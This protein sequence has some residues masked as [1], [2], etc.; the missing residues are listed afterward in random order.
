MQINRLFEIVYLLL[1]KKSVTAKELAERFEVSPRTIYRDID[2]LSEAGIPVYANRGTGGGIRLMEEF[3]L[4]KSYLS[5]AEQNDILS[6]LQGL[7][8]IRVPD[9][10]PVLK[11]LAALFGKE[12]AG[13]IDVD[14][15]SW[16]GGA[17]ERDKF[18]LLKNAILQRKVI[19]FS[20]FSGEGEKT[21]RTVEPLKILF[22]GMGWYLYG[23]CRQKKDFRVF[24]ISRMKNLLG[25]TENFQREIPD[26]IFQNTDHA[27][28]TEMVP[29]VMKIEADQAFRVYDAFQ[30]EEVTKNADGSFTVHAVMPGGAWLYGFLLSFGSSMEVLEPPEIRNEM[31]Q[32]AE[33]ILQKY[34]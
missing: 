3:V 19:S 30:P 12:Q 6:S 34:R 8:A 13:W 14:F 21:E 32:N 11:K 33:K 7:N 4:N 5:D 31:E 24:K 17:D 9:V 10:E 26:H 25:S 20:Y 2:T 27:Y 28:H 15:S 23:F 18:A 16:G 29:L 1:E 22:K